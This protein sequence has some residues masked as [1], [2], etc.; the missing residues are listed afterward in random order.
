MKRLAK[1]VSW[2]EAAALC[3]RLEDAG[4]RAATTSENSLQGLGIVY[5]EQP[6]VWIDDDADIDAALAVYEAFRTDNARVAMICP[7]CGYDLR[8]HVDP[9]GRC[10][11]RRCPECGR[12][13][14]PLP[15]DDVMCPKCSE[16]VPIN[17]DVC[18][19]CGELMAGRT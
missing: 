1:M 2:I 19:N 13:F 11:P 12:L 5:G 17:F 3:G 6:G 15:G 18:W 14:R 7:D 10:E 8:G 4:I 9:S 16:A